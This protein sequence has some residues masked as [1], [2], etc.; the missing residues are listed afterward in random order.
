MALVSK[1]ALMMTGR[2]SNRPIHTVNNYD[3]AQ[4]QTERRAAQC[5]STRC[6]VI[7]L[8]FCDYRKYPSLIFD[9]KII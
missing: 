4:A 9:P 6:F 2:Y 1:I 3:A 8:L 7:N 5:T